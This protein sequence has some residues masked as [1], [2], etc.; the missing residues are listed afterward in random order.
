VFS[1]NVLEHIEDEAGALATLREAVL[2][3][4]RLCLI[5]PAHP[6]LYG[7]MDRQAGHYRRYTRRSLKRALEQAGWIVH[8][9]FYINALGGLGWYLNQR[10]LPARPLDSVR[11]N[12]QLVLYDRLLVPLARC[13][14]FLTQHVFG[15]SVVAVAEK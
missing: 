5:V 4:A 2:P 10:L 8:S 7:Y 12:T 15:L 6:R 14:D 9:A 11:I 3:G 13:T 1:S